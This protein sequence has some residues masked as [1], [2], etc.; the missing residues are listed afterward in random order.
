MTQIQSGDNNKEA[1]VI[2]YSF[3]MVG[4]KA[5]HMVF[6]DSTANLIPESVI[7]RPDTDKEA[8]LT[9]IGFSTHY[10]T[11]DGKVL[12]LYFN[13]TA[14]DKPEHNWVSTY[15]CTLVAAS[16]YIQMDFILPSD[17]I[18]GF[19]E[20]VHETKLTQGAWTMWN[21]NKQPEADDDPDRGGGG[22]LLF[23]LILGV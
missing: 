23:W 18:Y 17:E 7:P 1:T 10:G 2:D 9:D 21:K 19:G 11:V 22:F 5:L 13:V 12:P 3:D 16:K 4:P 20:R 14:D 8:K 15:D 6:G